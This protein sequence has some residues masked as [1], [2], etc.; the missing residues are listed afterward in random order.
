M[1]LYAGPERFRYALWPL[2][3]GA[4]GVAGLILTRRT[5]PAILWFWVGALAVVL[6]IQLDASLPLWQNVPFVRFIQFPWRLYGIIA[7]SIAILFGALFAGARLT[8]WSAAWKPVVAAAALLALFAWL[9][10]ANLRPA[11]LPNWEMT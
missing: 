5:R 1:S 3:A 7:F 9:S 6:L 4:A 10:I 8:S 11:L 2:L